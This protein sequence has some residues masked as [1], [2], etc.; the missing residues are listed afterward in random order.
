MTVAQG[1]YFGEVVAAIRDIRKHPLHD[2][3]TELLNKPVFRV[4]ASVL[5]IL[6][7]TRASHDRLVRLLRLLCK[8]DTSTNSSKVAL[9]TSVPIDAT[10][11]RYLIWRRSVQ[12]PMF[13]RGMTNSM[14]EDRTEKWF[15]VQAALQRKDFG[16]GRTLC[17][18]LNEF[19][20]KEHKK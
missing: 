3:L 19:A 1:G 15:Q 17:A 20:E 5:E 2:V 13:L 7:L 10:S 8:Q 9:G 4:F 6:R 11:K 12:L 16:R 14:L 18:S